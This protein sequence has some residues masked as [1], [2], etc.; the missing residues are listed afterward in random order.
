MNL[1]HLGA[2][3]ILALCSACS[4]PGGKVV[5]GDTRPSIAVNGA[6]ATAVLE[7]DGIVHG[8]AEE[9]NGD[10]KVLLI[11]SGTHTVRVL[12]GDEVL[13]SQDIYVSNGETRVLTLKRN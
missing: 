1:V 7:V 12:D 11:E 5:R 3:L 8:N 9:F 4:Y 6:P 2:V 10:P 13:L